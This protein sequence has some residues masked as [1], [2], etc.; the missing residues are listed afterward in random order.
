M[1]YLFIRTHLASGHKDSGSPNTVWFLT[2]TLYC[3][4]PLCLCSHYLKHFPHSTHMLHPA[5]SSSSVKLILPQPLWEPLLLVY[6]IEIICLCVCCPLELRSSSTR[7]VY[8]SH[9]RYHIL[10]CHYNFTHPQLQQMLLQRRGGVSYLF[11][12]A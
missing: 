10:H 5:N 7:D 8:S 12:C 2:R 1:T 3:S 6:Y 4:I 9:L 11:P